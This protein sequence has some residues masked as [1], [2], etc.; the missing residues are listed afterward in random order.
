M[1][2]GAEGPVGIRDS[3]A[4]HTPAWRA[5]RA[6]PRAGGRACPVRGRGSRSA[7][8]RPVTS[9]AVLPPPPPTAGRAVDATKGAWGGAWTVVYGCL[10]AAL[11]FLSVAVIDLAV[12]GTAA[13]AAAARLQLTR[14]PDDTLTECIEVLDGTGAALVG[15]LG[16][17]YWAGAVLSVLAVAAGLGVLRRSEFARRAA[18]VLL[19]ASLLHAIGSVVLWAVYVL[20]AYRTWLE[21]ASRVWEELRRRDPEAPDLSALFGTGVWQH[22]ATEIAVQIL[23]AAIVLLLVVRVAGAASKAWCAPRPRIAPPGGLR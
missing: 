19:A 5:G 6:R 16:P 21:S 23:H 17:F 22:L 12:R 8:I 15:P 1:T 2:D 10:G 18:L 4:V 7:T 9:P 11:W 20:P 13:L 14:N 3:F